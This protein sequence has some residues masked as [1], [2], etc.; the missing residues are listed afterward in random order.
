MTAKLT[1]KAFG[2]RKAA[3][4]SSVSAKAT[5]KTNVFK[6]VISGDIGP[7]HMGQELTADHQIAEYFR[8]VMNE[9]SETPTKLNDKQIV[10]GVKHVSHDDLDAE[11][12]EQAVVDYLQTIE[13]SEEAPKYDRRQ[14]FQLSTLAHSAEIDA[15]KADDGLATT[16]NIAIKGKQDWD[17]APILI[18]PQLVRIYGEEH[19]RTWPKIDSRK[20]GKTKPVDTVPD[21]FTGPTDW[22]K[23]PNADNAILRWRDLFVEEMPHVKSKMKRL[24]LVKLMLKEG[25][26]TNLPSN[27]ALD[28]ELADCVNKDD[29]TMVNTQALQDIRDN[30]AKYI[31]QNKERMGKAI[32]YW[33][34]KDELRAIESDEKCIVR[35]RLAHSTPEKTAASTKPIV[36]EAKHVNSEG[37]A[38]WSMQKAISLA[39]FLRFDVP[40]ARKLS[41]K[42]MITLDALKDSAKKKQKDNN[43][44]PKPDQSKGIE[45]KEIQ[46]VDNFGD[47][48]F[49]V[50]NYLER[51]ATSIKAALKTN[52]GG[53]IA[54]RMCY[55]EETLRSLIDETVQ[56]LSKQYDKDELAANK[57]ARLAKEEQEAA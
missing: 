18:V 17:G 4:K 25:G 14:I 53:L 34:I 40:K 52:K 54:N 35:F 19:M 13:S 12:W 51:H 6:V 44:G 5:D 55:L 33:Q 48:A 45:A 46:N 43:G 41:G 28:Q 36:P 15:G 2:T 37:E 32:K 3:D 57:A 39:T 1:G 23:V 49:H 10:A 30:L 22:F 29:R 7:F 26:A 50:W 16:L 38:S 42:G 56:D 31:T 9:D 47:V 11:Q 20:T 27:V 8:L 24:D 21:S